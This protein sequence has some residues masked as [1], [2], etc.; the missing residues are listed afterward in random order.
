M[1]GSDASF[2][3]VEFVGDHA[4]LVCAEHLGDD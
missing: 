3:F 4:E 2:K 1:L